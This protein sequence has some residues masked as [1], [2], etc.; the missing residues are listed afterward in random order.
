MPWL[1]RLVRRVRGLWHR[2]RPQEVADELAFHL[3]ALTEQYE[4]D[5]FSRADARAKATRD[6]GNAARVAEDTS[7]VWTLPWLEGLVRDAAVGGRHLRKHPLV[8]A[9]AV[10]SLALGIGANTAVFSIVDALLLKTLPVHE[11]ERLAALSQGDQETTRVDGARWS[12][13]FW[14][15]FAR[16]AEHFDGVMAWSP[17][18]VDI[19]H[20]GQSE[21]VSSVFVSG[22]YFSTLRV[23]PA[24]GRV[25]EPGDDS[26]GAAPVAVLSHGYWE[27]RFGTDPAVLG[28]TILLQG[29][30][31]TVVGIAARG[32]PGLEVGQSFD[33][34]WPL[35][36]E[37]LARGAQ[38]F[39]QPPLD[40]M[41]MWLRIGVRRQ[42]GQ[43]LK[44][45]TALVQGLH[46]A[47][48]DASLPPEAPQLATVMLQEP[49]RLTDASTGLSRLRQLYRRPLVLL[50][51]VVALLLLLACVNVAS[52]LLAQAT[53]RGH[54][55]SV[56]L[57]LGGSRWRV[58]RQLMM[59]SAI[60]AA[61]GMAAGLGVAY[62]AARVLL[63]RVSTQTAVVSLDLPID[64]RVLAFTLAVG[65]VTTLVAGT[66]AAWR[67]N[68]AAPLALLADGARG[69][70][71][72]RRAWVSSL[73]LSAQVGLSLALVIIAGL[74]ISTFTAL[75]RVPL[76]FDHERVLL[77]NVNVA[78]AAVAPDA[79][80]ALYHRYADLAQTVPGVLQA[81]AA[82]STPV[83]ATVAPVA[84]LSPG[85]GAASDRV[86]GEAKSVFVT[87]GWFA[88]YGVP[89]LRGRDIA[90]HDA[91]E[92][93]AVM[94][95][96]QA[97]VDRFLSQGDV[98][99][100][101]RGLAVG[102]RAEVT[103]RSR[104]IVGVAGTS[105][106]RS[107]RESPEPTVYVPLA[108]YDYPI[109]LSA[110][111]N[112]SVRTASDAP[113]SVAADLTAALT[114]VTPRATVTTRTLTSQVRD[115]YRQEQLL[116]SL[117]AVFGGIALL[118]AACGL[119]GVTYY[120]VVRR[121]AELA[122]RIAVG[123]GRADVIRTVLGRLV[124][125]IALGVA[126]GMTLA[127]WLS[128]FVAT[129]LFGV[130]PGD[131]GTMALAAAVLV[132][133]SVTAALAPAVRANRI[134]PVATLR[135]S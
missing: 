111:I 28:S 21:S 15:A 32:F 128:R 114:A 71:G 58:A 45:G 76:G 98:L 102:R 66:A 91:N 90:P 85:S 27:R 69:T 43:S 37:T 134:S 79:R 83:S 93:P 73:L 75:S 23:G 126:A 125:P 56:R 94:V 61:L 109:A 26:P 129:L 121:R 105:V 82:S 116:A 55:L 49:L 18:R 100:A 122:V 22:D 62:A 12:Y 7:G 11:P 47:L 29:H 33:I 14:Q 130:A 57:A 131:L 123:A 1:L 96:N 99:G 4:A 24:L 124:P 89:V 40:R 107:L 5:G 42:L 19:E 106:Y 46:S 70:I 35:P 103:L 67:V 44:A 2:G 74:F 39:L 36:T 10:L 34:A 54:E 80:N 30:S 112:L 133:V 59:E 53:A 78:Q 72:V 6:F 25:I 104:E 3:D 132:G 38:S 31:V 63:A 87:P 110:F 48:V 52:L 135:A 50:A 13:A 92:S 113:A 86:L 60:L 101:V 51:I 81:T 41:N 119:F 84:V 64:G 97:F 8:S 17:A 120:A 118:L 9:F 115:S 77:A 65:L 95:V 68:A 20:D 117:S 88:T 16:H 108:Q 127:F